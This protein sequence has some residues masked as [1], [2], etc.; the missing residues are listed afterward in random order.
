M[1]LYSRMSMYHLCCVQCSAGRETDVQ[2]FRGN[3]KGK[4]SKIL[5]VTVNGQCVVQCSAV[6]VPPAL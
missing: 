6:D 2:C 1:D 4:G 3:S 5:A